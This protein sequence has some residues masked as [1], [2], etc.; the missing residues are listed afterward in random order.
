MIDL[1][2]FAAELMARFLQLVHAARKEALACGGG[3]HQQDRRSAL[4]SNPLDLFDHAVE[5]GIPGCDAQFQKR[6]SLRM[7]Q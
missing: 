2:E 5:I 3:T 7:G 1:D 4:D 6:D